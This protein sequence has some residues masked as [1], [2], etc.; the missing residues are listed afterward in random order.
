L[1]EILSGDEL[2]IPDSE[3]EQIIKEVDV[4]NDNMI[5]YNEFLEMMKKDLKVKLAVYNM[6]LKD[7]L[8]FKPQCSI[9]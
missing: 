6:N 4:N 5:D 3:I 9:F 7:L 2:Q 1:K 8:V